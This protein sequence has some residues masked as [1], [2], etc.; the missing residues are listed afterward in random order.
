MIFDKIKHCKYKSNLFDFKL[1]EL[2]K[3]VYLLFISLVFKNF[4]FI[5]VKKK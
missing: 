5:I 1:I 4:D 2:K 3:N